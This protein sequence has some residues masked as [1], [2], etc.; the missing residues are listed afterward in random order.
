MARHV[1]SRLHGFPWKKA[2]RAAT[3]ETNSSKLEE[4][5][6]TA[7]RALLARSIELKGLQQNE[8]EIRGIE[9]AIRTLWT[10]RWRRLGRA[11]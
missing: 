5:I 3:L 1:S 8:R 10:I 6:R 2:Y 4:R 7:E 9:N 11:A